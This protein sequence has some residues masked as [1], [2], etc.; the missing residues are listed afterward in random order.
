MRKL[1][2]EA[3]LSFILHEILGI[4]IRTEETV[5]KHYI[6]QSLHS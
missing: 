6:G 5:K 1:V 2:K 4:S 3:M